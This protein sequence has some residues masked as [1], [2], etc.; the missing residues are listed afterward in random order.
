MAAIVG[1][2]VV[3]NV[4]SFKSATKHQARLE[5]AVKMRASLETELVETGKIEEIDIL[6]PDEDE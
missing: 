4:M 1:T 2:Y 6:D 3:Y 5:E